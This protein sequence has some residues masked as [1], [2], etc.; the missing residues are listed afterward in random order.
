MIGRT[1]TRQWVL[2]TMTRR[3]WKNVY[4]TSLRQAA[5]LCVQHALE[6]RNKSVERI[7]EE[8][9][10]PSHW[11][12]YKWLESGRMPLLN[13][14][15]F[16]I[17]CGIDFITKYMAHSAS[18]L[19]IDIPTGRKAEHRELSEL[20]LFM[21]QAVQHLY[22]YQDGQKTADDVI[23]VITSL[24]EDLAHQRG[25]LEKAAQPELDFEEAHKGVSS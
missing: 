6:K 8:M 20:N 23:G 18:Y 24:M 19:A 7:A 4:P 22:E 2:S 17:A 9:G 15:P 21:S 16:E 14:R 10:I 13:I 12:L 11:T 25:N 5:E 3:S 1:K